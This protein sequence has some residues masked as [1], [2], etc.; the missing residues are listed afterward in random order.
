[1]ATAHRRSGL[2]TCL[3]AG[4]VYGCLFVAIAAAQIDTSPKDATAP[5]RIAIAQVLE[6][7]RNAV[8]TG[9]EAL[10]STTLLDDQIPFFAVSE[11]RAPVESQQMRGVAAFRKAV[12]HSGRRYTQ[13]FD[14][15]RIAQDGALA[16]ATL[17]FV[18]QRD[19][20]SGAS[21]WKTLTLLDTGGHWKIASEFY[22]VRRL[23]SADAPAAAIP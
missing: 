8:S 7:Y 3:G 2:R 6:N 18:T 17:R 14:D 19:D 4:S 1:M 21:G 12:F 20:G 22:T 11:A 16:Q 9:D 10:F 5:D 15:I 23:T 13:R